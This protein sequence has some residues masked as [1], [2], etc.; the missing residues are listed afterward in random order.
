MNSITVAPAPVALAA[1]ERGPSTHASPAPVIAIV[2]LGYVGL[3][4]ALALADAGFP[5]LGVDASDDRL[6]EIR[7]ADVD[8]AGED[9]RRLA[10]ALLDGASR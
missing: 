9:R 8:L 3:P 1:P 6:A 2:G 10:V 4:T 7:R 5:V